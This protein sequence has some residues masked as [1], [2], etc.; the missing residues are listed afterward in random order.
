M[1]TS[2]SGEDLQNPAE[3]ADSLNTYFQTVFIKEKTVLK[4]KKDKG[5]P[6]FGDGKAIFSLEALYREIDNLK[7]NKAIGMDKA[8]HIILK[9]CKAALSRPWLIIFLIIF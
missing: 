8:S 6:H 5:L 4:R 9:K 1:L 7:D 3:L 2:D